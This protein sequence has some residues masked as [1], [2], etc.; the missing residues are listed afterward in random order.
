MYYQGEIKRSRKSVKGYVFEV[1]VPDYK[2]SQKKVSTIVTIGIDD[3]RKISPGQ[4]SILHCFF[5]EI[6][7]ATGHT[8]REIKEYLKDEFARESDICEFSLSTVDM[9]TARHF[10]EHV[11]EFMFFHGIEVSQKVQALA[12]GVGNHLYLCLK[13][14]TC[15]CCWELAEVHHIDAIGMGRDRT[16]A[17]HA[18][19][20]LIALC[21]K[22]HDEAH[23]SGWTGFSLKHHVAGLKLNEQ[24]IKELGIK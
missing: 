7:R 2:P 10:I 12:K 1:H 18:E 11:L 23:S 19:H 13:F 20:R 17:N 16:Q 15:A 3:G 4:Q 22:H 6:A 14:R 21:R 8:K 24:T 5:G 9:T